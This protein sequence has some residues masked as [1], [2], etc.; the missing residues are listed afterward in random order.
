[1]DIED[2]YRSL[3]L[4]WNETP[5]KDVLILMG[6]WDSK[7]GK[8]EEPG[9][10]GRYGLGNRNEAGE[11]LLE[12]CEQND[13]FLANTYFEQPEERFY[14]WTSPDGQYRNQIDYILGRRR[15]RSAFQS[16]K[17]RPDAECGLDH[18]LL[19]ATVRI[20][21]KSTQHTEKGWQLDTDNIPEEY[22]T[23]IKQKL[24]TMNTQGGNSEEIWKALKDAFKEVANKTIL[25]N[26][27]RKGPFWMSQDTLRVV[28]NR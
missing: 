6:D 5:K 19:T 18:E 15:W 27:E 22:K 4:A 23:E 21:L 16:V 13:L 8:G 9:M 7:I 11:R 2:F 14:T 10:V 25:R 1:V 3:N 26:E 28:E 12:F 20:K 17:T 24:A